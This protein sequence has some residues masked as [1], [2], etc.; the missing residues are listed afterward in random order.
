M[1]INM[2]DPIDLKFSPADERLLDV[3]LRNRIHTGNDHEGLIK[4]IKLYENEPWLLPHVN[5]ED[6][7]ENEWF[8]FVKRERRCGNRTRRTVVK[9]GIEVGTWKAAVAMTNIFN[10]NKE[11]IGYYTILAYYQKD[12]RKATGWNMT[13]Y[14]LQGDDEKEFQEVV[15]CHIRMKKDIAEEFRFRPMLLLENNNNMDNRHQ[16][17]DDDRLMFNVDDL[18]GQ[19]IPHDQTQDSLLSFV[20]DLENFLE[21]EDDPSLL[22]KDRVE[23]GV[24]ELKQMIQQHQHDEFFHNVDQEAGIS[25]PQQQQYDDINNVFRS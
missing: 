24:A 21:Q 3:Y 4:D 12:K 9:G 2:A 6:F 15:L 8:Y 5:N 11:L 25:Q 22:I 14:C 20:G 17:M 16:D 10:K 13:E 19:Q 23:E 7:I 18:I 1:D